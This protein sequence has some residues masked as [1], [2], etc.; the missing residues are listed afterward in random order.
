[1]RDFQGATKKASG[2]CSFA[3]VGQFVSPIPTTPPTHPPFFGHLAG[4]P[5]PPPRAR[6]SLQTASNGA[7]ADGEF[8]SLLSVAGAPAATTTATRLP[9]LRL[10]PL[11]PPPLRPPPLP[12][13]AAPEANAADAN[14][15]VDEMASSDGER[16][17][18]GE[19]WSIESIYQSAG[20][21]RPP[22]PTDRR[23]RPPT[24][25]PYRSQVSAALLPHPPHPHDIG[26]TNCHTGAKELN[27]E[28]LYT[29]AL[30]GVIYIQLIFILFVY[31]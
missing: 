14:A 18:V 30:L 8:N 9:P 4:P 25:P 7:G 19:G 26:D 1:M 10:S 12:A 15:E 28:L 11:R 31:S 5:A 6:R 3:P 21:T 13:A 2:F 17:C 24:P 23:R 20:R 22:P 16:V 29:Y 27:P